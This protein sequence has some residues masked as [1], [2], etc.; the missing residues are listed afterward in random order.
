[1]KGIVGILKIE[2]KQKRYNCV[3]KRETGCALGIGFSCFIVPREAANRE[4]MSFATLP[5]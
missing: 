2:R 1:L 4:V 5:Q 3:G